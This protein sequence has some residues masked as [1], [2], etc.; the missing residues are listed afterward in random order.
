MRQLDCPESK[1]LECY[2]TLTAT[3]LVQAWRYVAMHQEEIDKE[4]QEN[5][6][7]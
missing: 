2:P 4:I 1:I 6:Q 3:D 5:E 7:D